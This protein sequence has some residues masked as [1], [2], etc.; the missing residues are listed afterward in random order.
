[1]P[2]P[3]AA[4]LGIGLGVTAGIALGIIVFHERENI[5]DH[6]Q[7]AFSDLKVAIAA[8]AEQ[9]SRRRRAARLLAAAS[10]NQEMMEFYDNYDK[11]DGFSDPEE[12]ALMQPS[13]E[14][15]RSCQEEKSRSS[16]MPS[17]SEGLRHRNAPH[18]RYSTSDEE[19]SAS[20]YEIVDKADS[21]IYRLQDAHDNVWDTSSEASIETPPIQ[22]DSDEAMSHD[23][24]DFGSGLGDT[25]SLSGTSEG[26][27]FVVQ[28]GDESSATASHGYLTEDEESLND[29][30]RIPIRRQQRSSIAN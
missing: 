13:S 5:A 12:I 11:E 24:S 21:R 15:I 1:M 25:A 3:A 4:V 22:S 7:H 27:E 30:E 2:L 26:F 19:G 23:G 8:I 9:R 6:I 18:P 20:R 17:S 29:Y 28:S 10:D 14:S 16:A